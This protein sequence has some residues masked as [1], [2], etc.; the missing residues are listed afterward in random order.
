LRQQDDTDARLA[1]KAAT[2]L[3]DLPA[4]TRHTDPAVIQAKR[5]V[6]E[7]ALARARARQAAKGGN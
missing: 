1:A 5:Q 3:A 6:I 7:A 2:K 4:H